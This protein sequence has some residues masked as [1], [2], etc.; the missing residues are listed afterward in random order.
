MRA[1]E[2]FG[3]TEKG[4][5]ERNE[6]AFLATTLGEVHLFALAEGM[7]GPPGE[8]TPAQVAIG[9]LSAGKVGGGMG[10]LVDLLERLLAEADE[11][12]YSLV[13]RYPDSEPPA[14]AMSLALIDPG[15]ECIVSSP[16]SRKVFF[17]A[18]DRGRPGEGSAIG[19]DGE[20]SLHDP[21]GGMHQ[22]SLPPG[23]LVLCSDGVGDFVGDTRLEEI[24]RE[25]GDDLEAACRTI[26]S[27]A[28]SN[29]SD[30]NLT[31]VLVRR[32]EP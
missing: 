5:R 22:A 10:S 6:D 17:L 20:F 15:G 16:G 4:L 14:V 1:I 2:H 9:A 26:V 30:D 7:G 18:A 32:Q 25:R 11:A 28:F 29:G 21:G 3:L 13:T 31:I 27:E 23:F 19:T 24:V 8:P 12:L